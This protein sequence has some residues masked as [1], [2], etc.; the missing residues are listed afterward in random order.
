MRSTGRMDELV[1]NYKE[2]DDDFYEDLSDILIMADVG[3]KTTASWRSDR[4]REKCTS[5]KIG[6]PAEGARGAEGD[7][8]GHHDA[9]SPCSWNSPMVLLVIGVNGVGKTTTIGK[10]ATPLQG[11]AA[12]RWFICAGD[13]FRAAAADQLDRLGRSA[14]TCPSSSRRRAQTP[15]PWCY[16]GVQ[17]AQGPPRGHAASSIPPAV[18]TTR[19]T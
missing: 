19:P 14:R 6:D 16:D 5:E 13:T 8:G 12:A 10:L 18:C 1:E 15:P 9:P 3:M 2:L 11:R 4:L 17:A 7:S